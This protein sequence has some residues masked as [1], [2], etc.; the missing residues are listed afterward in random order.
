GDERRLRLFRRDRRRRGPA[1][2]RSLAG[3][4][5]AAVADAA[6]RRVREWAPHA[7]SHRRAARGAARARVLSAADGGASDKSRPLRIASVE[8]M[9]FHFGVSG[10]SSSYSCGSLEKLGEFAGLAPLPCKGAVSA[11][12]ASSCPHRPQSCFLPSA[13]PGAG[14]RA[15]SPSW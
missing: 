12:A 15:S 10:G 13:P 9:H 7:G 3:R 4:D 6:P 14:G 8:V 11:L 5:F 2:A 1:M